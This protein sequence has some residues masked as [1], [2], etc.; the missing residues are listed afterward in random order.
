MMVF[1]IA[2]CQGGVTQAHMGLDKRHFSMTELF[3]GESLKDGPRQPYG[4]TSEQRRLQ[5]RCKRT[6]YCLLFA[7]LGREQQ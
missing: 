2:L 3:C 4:G 7:N 1:E 5:V 6:S